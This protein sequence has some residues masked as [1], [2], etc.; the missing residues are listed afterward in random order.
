MKLVLT[1]TYDNV[2]AEWL[3]WYIKRLGE[4]GLGVQAINLEKHGRAVL[5]SNDPTSKAT[6]RTT[7]E[8]ISPRTEK[9]CPRCGRWCECGGESARQDTG[10]K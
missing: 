6:A 4:G 5:E 1:T 9:D 7:Y 3:A 10:P 8:V 2:D